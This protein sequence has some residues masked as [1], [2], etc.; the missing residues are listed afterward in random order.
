MDIRVVHD[1]EGIATAP[2]RRRS[3]LGRLRRWE[4][5]LLCFDSGVRAE[6][7]RG[8]AEQPRGPGAQRHP[9]ESVGR[10]RPF[11]RDGT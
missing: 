8:D 9:S 6:P 2:A 4:G 11:S 5:E 7:Q 1:L 3:P 10:D